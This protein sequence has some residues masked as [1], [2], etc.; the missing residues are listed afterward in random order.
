MYNCTVTY[1]TCESFGSVYSFC[2]NVYDVSYFLILPIKYLI[3]EDGEPTKP[4][5]L[6]TSTDK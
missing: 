2:I 3:N 1:G 6:T 4:L 5:K